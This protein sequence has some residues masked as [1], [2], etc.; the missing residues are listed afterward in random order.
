MNIL[1]LTNKAPYP[2]KDGGS[3]ATFGMIKSFADADHKVSVLAMNTRKHHVTPFEI[4]DEIKALITIHLVEVPAHIKMFDMIRNLLVSKLPYNAERFIDKH[5]KTKLKNLLTSFK[6]DVI[7]LE[8]LYL[9]PYI[10]TIRQH[11]SAKIIYRSHNVEHEIWERAVKQAKGIKKQ[12][13]KTLTNRLKKFEINALNSYDAI[14]P[15]TER[16]EKRHNELG[17]YKPSLSIPAGFNFDGVEDIVEDFEMNLQFIGALDWLPN[18]EGLLWFFDNCWP[19]ILK[20]QPQLKLKVAGRNAP[21]WMEQKIKAQANVVYLGEIP[22]AK[23]YIL[24]N[25][26]MIAPLLSGSGMRVKI[27]EGMLYGKAIVSTP[28]GCEGIPVTNKEEIYIGEDAS[29][30]AKHCLTLIQNRKKII[31]T[32]NKALKFVQQNYNNDLLIKKLIE[33]YKQVN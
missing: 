14:I 8:G 3:I 2:P 19:S 7:Q 11:S 22:D 10:E 24:E 1:F 15:I 6:Y 12:Y 32:G 23:S 17:N 29:T 20:A 28:V 16:D 9:C 26:V 25:G 31:A 33:F 21:E 5:Y 13:L 18:Q 30:F 27:I 4:P